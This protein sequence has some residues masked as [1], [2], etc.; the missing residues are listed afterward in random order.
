LRGVPV[1]Q[2]TPSG[3]DLLD[4]LRALAARRAELGT[5]AACPG[6]TTVDEVLSASEVVI[7]GR[8][9]LM[10]GSNNYL[11]LT[12]H[13][14]VRAAARDAVDRYGIGTTGS[15]AAN[16]T[17]AIHTS[18]ERD[19]ADH[20][21]K[22]HALIFTTGYQANLSVIAGV[23]QA[24]NV[25]LVDADSH[26]SIYDAARLSGATT[27]VFRHNAPD[28]LARK[29]A[30]LP[31]GKRDRLVVVE[32]AYSVRGDV[33]PL[34]EIVTVCREHAAYLLVDEAHSFGA[35][36]ARGLG[37]AESEG[38]LGDVDFVV[39]TF[40]KALGS[41]GGFCV[42]NRPEIESLRFLARSYV[43]TASGSA[44]TIEG[45]RAALRVI[46]RDP[47]LRERLWANTRRLRA[48]LISGGCT[49]G[50]VESP[51]VSIPV[52]HEAGAIELWRR[53]L[54][55]GVYVNIMLPPACPP[56]ACLLRASCSAAH[57][58][59]EIDR[60][61]FVIARIV[62]EADVKPIADAVSPVEGD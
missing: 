44:S 26:A 32:G 43:F 56:D 31:S 50:P 27:I 48:G 45:V 60:G 12:F 24:G 51:I 4:R 7:R 25:L 28:D 33:A 37:L 5:E 49:I 15:R 21:G 29:M 61:A 40:S 11:G 20:F 10:L 3:G 35:Y 16:G 42:S 14:E 13:P 22:R 62:R 38:V 36:G 9:T 55:A 53:L 2:R 19:L 18:L 34:K 8:R 41:V 17:L 6:D 1:S 57:T 54:E 46:A 59:S 47:S 52:G 39:G 30:R 58:P 23:C